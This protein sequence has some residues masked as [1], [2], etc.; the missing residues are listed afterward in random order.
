MELVVNTKDWGG[1]RKKGAKRTTWKTLEKEEKCVLILKIISTTCFVCH[2]QIETEVK[3]IEWE[4]E[5]L[6]W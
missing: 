5:V 4:T 6:Y 1:D 3:S 2:R